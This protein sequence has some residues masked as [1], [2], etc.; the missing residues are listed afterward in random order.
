MAKMLNAPIQKGENGFT[1]IE[2]IIVVGII[3]VLA[4]IAIPQFSAYRTRS[5]N[6][7]AMADLRNA[8]SAQEAYHVDF[9]VYANSSSV[10]S[11]SYGLAISQ[12]I[13]LSATGSASGYS[14]TAYHSSGDKTYTIEGPGGSV[15]S[16]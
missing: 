15:S 5:F 12:N 13:S 1:L 9:Q 11:A 14:M 8:A 16:L 6:S 4:A 7:N 2:L 10:L 3:G